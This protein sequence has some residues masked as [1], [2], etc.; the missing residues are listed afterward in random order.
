[1]APP[2]DMPGLAA[3]TS[4]DAEELH[5]EGK[6]KNKEEAGGVEK[7]PLPTEFPG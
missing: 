6:T 5:T 3:G 4:K 2:E 1:M 7:A